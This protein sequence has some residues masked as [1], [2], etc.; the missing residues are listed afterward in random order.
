MVFIVC[1]HMFGGLTG[2][3]AY[4]LFAYMYIKIYFYL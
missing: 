1:Y 3:L 2:L 4:K